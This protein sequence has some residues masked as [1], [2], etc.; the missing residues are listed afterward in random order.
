MA[1]QEAAGGP[2]YRAL[3]DARV[4][5]SNGGGLAAEDFRVDVPGPDATEQKV[6]ELFLASLGLLLTDQVHVQR[7]R[8]VQEQHRGTRRGPSSS[9]LD[10]VPAKAPDRWRHVDLAT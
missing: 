8:V 9:S 4:T 7:L 2:E 10:S 5:F 3:F 6:G 1:D